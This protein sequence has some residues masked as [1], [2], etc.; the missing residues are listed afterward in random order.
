MHTS[1]ELARQADE[2]AAVSPSAG[3]PANIANCQ[4]SKCVVTSTATYIKLEGIHKTCKDE[5]AIFFQECTKQMYQ[6]TLLRCQTV[7]M[8]CLCAMCVTNLAH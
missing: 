1:I 7:S 6:T 4:H 2:A 5:N 8:L 3:K